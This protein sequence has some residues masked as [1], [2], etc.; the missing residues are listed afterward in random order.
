ML[1]N[2]VLTK[3]CSKGFNRFELTDEIKSDVVS[4]G[5][6]RFILTLRLIRLKIISI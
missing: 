1:L 6:H 3:H 5:T 2:G 4:A